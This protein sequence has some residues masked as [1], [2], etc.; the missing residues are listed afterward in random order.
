M[1]RHLNSIRLAGT[2]GA[3]LEAQA[4]P[5]EKVDEDCVQ[6]KQPIKSI[7]AIA[8]TVK[9]QI[10]TKRISMDQLSAVLSSITELANKALDNVRQVQ[11]E[12]TPIEAARNL[13]FSSAFADADSQGRLMAKSA[14]IVREAWAQT[15]L[16]DSK[17]K[18]PS[19]LK[20]SFVSQAYNP[21]KLFLKV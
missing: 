1:H 4:H 16:T 6:A 17:D 3:S 7:V 13:A 14:K 11:T 2:C 12:L 18:V 5:L 8:D 15:L 21:S 20:V 10:R 9:D 19:Q